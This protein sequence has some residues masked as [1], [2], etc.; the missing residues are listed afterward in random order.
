MHGARCDATNKAGHTP[1]QL[2][3]RVVQRGT[4]MSG[5]IVQMLRLFDK[6][7]RGGSRRKSP[8]D[9]QQDQQRWQPEQQHMEERQPRAHDQQALL[10]MGM[11]LGLD[12]AAGNEPLP[13]PMPVS[14]PMSMPMSM[15][16]SKAV[17]ASGNGSPV[18]R[19]ADALDELLGEG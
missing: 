5:G 18:S 2:A 15:S 14:M 13:P 8:Q 1:K 12:V 9:Q 16:K 11:G 4:S 6:A 19:E 10:G 17:M 3:L 7:A